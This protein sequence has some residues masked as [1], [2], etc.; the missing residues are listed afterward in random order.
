MQQTTQDNYNYNS[1][2]E[3]NF[4]LSE[5]VM[6]VVKKYWWSGDGDKRGSSE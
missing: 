5:A 4:Q 2:N 6:R 1:Y 3:D